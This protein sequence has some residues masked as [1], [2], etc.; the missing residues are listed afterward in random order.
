MIIKQN[1]KYWILSII[2]LFAS[3]LFSSSYF[4]SYR[5]LPLVYQ[6]IIVIS[7]WLLSGCSLFFS[8]GINNKF[9]KCIVVGANIFCI[10]G[11]WFIF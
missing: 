8:T 9:I 5:T 11:W 7:C 10:Y 4:S 3:C 1:N 2:F 6:G